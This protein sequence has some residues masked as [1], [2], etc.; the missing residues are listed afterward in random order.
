LSS[1]A[2]QFNR[3]QIKTRPRIIKRPSRSLPK[4]QSRSRNFSEDW[5]FTNKDYYRDPNALPDL[6]ALQKNVDPQNQLGFLRKPLEVKKYADLT[7]VT[8]A[9]E[10]LGAAEAH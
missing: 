2:Q 10:R 4:R 1:I 5:I 6:D 7:L 8:E 3:G 9:A